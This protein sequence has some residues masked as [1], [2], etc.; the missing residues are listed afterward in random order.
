MMPNRLIL[1]VSCLTFWLLSS[2]CTYTYYLRVE[3]NQ[4]EGALLAKDPNNQDLRKILLIVDSVAKLYKFDETA[5]KKP[6]TIKV[7]IRNGNRRGLNAFFGIG[8]I[9]AVSVDGLDNCIYVGIE[10][11]PNGGQSRLSRKVTR[12]LFRA[13]VDEFGPARV[14]KLVDVDWNPA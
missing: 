7:Y 10:D 11:D 4:T 1:G 14:E 6:R 2:G 12:D 5:P 13:L 3:T 9:M 8:T